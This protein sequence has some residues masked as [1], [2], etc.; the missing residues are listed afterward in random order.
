MLSGAFVDEITSISNQL[1]S[2]FL[3]LSLSCFELCCCFKRERRPVAALPPNET[4][5]TSKLQ[6]DVWMRAVFS[7]GQLGGQL[8]RQDSFRHSCFRI[9]GGGLWG[10]CRRV[11]SCL[12]RESLQSRVTLL[13]WPCWWKWRISLNWGGWDSLDAT[14]WLIIQAAKGKSAGTTIFTFTFKLGF[15]Y[16]HSPSLEAMIHAQWALSIIVCLY[17]RR[18]RIRIRH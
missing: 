9:R 7:R 1:F 16:K 5:E 18:I 17:S 6:E 13:R 10:L 11:L 15:T 12:V 4:G 14:F 3:S 8:K 2:P